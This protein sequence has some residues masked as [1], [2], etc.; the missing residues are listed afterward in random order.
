MLIGI[1][2]DT[3]VPPASQRVDPAL[4]DRIGKRG[5]ELTVNVQVVP[6]LKQHEN[7]GEYIVLTIPREVGV[8]LTSDGRYF[9]RVGDTCRP[10]VGD[11]VMRLAD[12]HPAT[13]WEEMTSQGVPRANRDA[14]KNQRFCAGLRASDRLNPLVKEKSDDELFTHYGLARGDVLTNL[15]VLLVGGTRDR[16]RLGSGPIVLAIKYDE[17]SSKIY[18]R[19]AGPEVGVGYP[20]APCGQRRA[21]AM[22]VSIA[23]QRSDTTGTDPGQALNP[24]STAAPRAGARRAHPHTGPRRRRRGSR[25]S[26]AAAPRGRRGPGV[27]L[28]RHRCSSACRS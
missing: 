7:G 23:S 18:D 14:A 24:G 20:G 10:M 15:G 9:L 26:A 11:D 5:G 28:R 22:H 13:P 8:A 3:D 25:G 19:Q 17:A 4:L 21:E 2:D 12:E 6:E 16:A 27:V 1:E